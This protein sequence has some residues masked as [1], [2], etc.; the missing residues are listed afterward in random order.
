MWDI[1]GTLL[2]GDSTSQNAVSRRPTAQVSNA[3]VTAKRITSGC[4]TILEL[5]TA[6]TIEGEQLNAGRRSERGSSR[7][8]TAARRGLPTVGDRNVATASEMKPGHGMGP[9]LARR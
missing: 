5:S 9:I 6:E 4:P 7:L 3:D 2:S 8:A 1:V